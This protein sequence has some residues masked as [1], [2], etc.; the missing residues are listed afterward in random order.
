MAAGASR[1]T[2]GLGSAGGDASCA[3]WAGGGALAAG[4]SWATW[5]GG[6]AFASEAIWLPE[7]VSGGVLA[8]AGRVDG[9]A[10]PERARWERETH[11]RRYTRR[12][13]R[14]EG[15]VETHKHYADK[16]SPPP[17]PREQRADVI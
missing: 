8:A 7:R 11:V 14:T 10:E 17:P 3:T 6:G 13:P 9:A 12:Y 5:D 1:A 16:T 2:V 4:L 15:V